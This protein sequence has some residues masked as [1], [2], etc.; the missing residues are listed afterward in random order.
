MTLSPLQILSLAAD[1]QESTG[2]AGEKILVVVQLTGGN[3]GL[4]T[5]VPFNDGAY[6]D[7]RPKIALKESQVLPLNGETGLHP[8][9]TAMAELFRQG[10]LAILEGV[11]YPNPNRSHFRSLEIWQTAQPEE[12]GS[13][14][15]LGRYVDLKTH[16]AACEPVPAVNVDPILPLS[17][18]A[19]K[20]AVPSVNNVSGFRLQT[21]PK[22][23]QDRKVP[24]E[25]FLDINSNFLQAEP[26]YRALLTQAG[27]DA[28]DAS[29]RLL[30]AAGK[31]ESK[32]KYPG[33]KLGDGLKFISQ[34]ICSGV[35]STVYTVSLDGFDTHANQPQTQAR[36]LKQLSDAIGAFQSDLEEHGVAPR[37][38]TAVFS[39]FGR[40]L[41]ENSGCGT[42][43]GTAEPLFIIGSGIK[44]G[45]YGSRPSLTALDNGD[46]KYTVDFRHVYA[47]LLDRWLQAD[48]VEILG[49]N[50][51]TL[52]FV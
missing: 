45:V 11:G 19:E 50:F 27:L 32:A 52:A 47:T 42:D 21:E 20:V 18:V 16:G 29:Q 34:M 31:Q 41:E 33:G 51:E 26:P 14:G 3:D 25:A 10:K 28:D 17:L 36:L 49:K 13:T 44:G 1:A 7:K 24:S 46:L 12:I 4:N 35:T 8:A 48:S 43:H 22:Y 6:F 40:R 38:L 15:W 9:M 39:E 30:K 2:R 37:V 23:K 5:V